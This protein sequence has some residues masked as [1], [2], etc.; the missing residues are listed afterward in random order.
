MSSALPYALLAALVVHFA[1]HVW[2]VVGLAAVRGWA[3]AALAFVVPPLAPWW[4]WEAGMR[5][6]AVAWGSALAAYA[7]L[8]AAA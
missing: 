2:I 1:A 8:V 6:R 5:R 7:I 4:G 3:R